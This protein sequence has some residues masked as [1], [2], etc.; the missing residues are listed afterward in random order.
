MPSSSRFFKPFFISTSSFLC[1]SLFV[2]QASAATIYWNGAGV[3][4]LWTTAANWS[5]SVVPAAGDIAVF[6]NVSAKNAF[7]PVNTSVGGLNIISSYTGTVAQSGGVLFTVGSGHLVVGGGTFR[8]GTGSTV[9]RGNLTLSG[10]TLKATSQALTVGGAFSRTGGSYTA[11][12]GTL[13]LS[14]SGSR[15][16]TPGSITFN[17][18]ALN[19]G[20]VGWWKLD[21]TSG[22]TAADQ[23]GYG[24]TG[25]WSVAATPTISSTVAPTSYANARSLSFNG[26]DNYAWASTSTSLQI[27]GA[28]TVSAW[29]KTSSVAACPIIASNYYGGQVGW[30][31]YV[32]GATGHLAFD[33]R[34][35]AA[36][37]HVAG[38]HTV[39]DNAW[40]H[41][42][43]QREGAAWRVYVDG[44]L[45][46]ET[47][48]GSAGGSI[49]AGLPIQ[50]GGGSQVG[51]DSYAGLI[52][53]LRIYSRA[54]SLS[55]IASLAAGGVPASP[56][57]NLAA[58]WPFDATP[59]DPRRPMLPGTAMMRCWTQGRLS[60]PPCRR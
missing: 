23:S 15:T 41:V 39:N 20:L 28:I 3:N 51:C 37:Q 53:D 50:I 32:D 44:A 49:D 33:G 54:L 59:R 2:M 24:N 58:Y 22:T 46:G 5:G 38:T 10:G 4:S 57:L 17:N 52:D 1:L 40:H 36:Y 30:F 25:T 7:I 55:D 60:R 56:T 9:V 42:V 35:T 14:S 11:N 6:S 19:D 18:V 21:E 45:D 16:L 27:S 29:I 26:T 8:G 13:V 47:T 34:P 48:T 43:G 31:L 12:N